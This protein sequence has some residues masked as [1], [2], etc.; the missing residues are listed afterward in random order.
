M[1]PADTIR[2]AL[3]HGGENVTWQCLELALD[4]AREAGMKALRDKARLPPEDQLAVALQAADEA[5]EEL[6]VELSGG[7]KPPAEDA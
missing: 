7:G 4:A 3:T 6:A 1:D 5:I 2:L